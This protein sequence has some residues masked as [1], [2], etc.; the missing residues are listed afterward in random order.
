VVRGGAAGGESLRRSWDL[1]RA[2]G[3]EQ[4]EP[5][6][7][8]ATL[9]ADTVR[10]VQR[11]CTL[12][13][14]VVLDVGAGPRQFAEAFVG[15]GARYVG[16]DADPDALQRLDDRRAHALI[17]SG[18]HLPVADGALDVVISSNVFEHVRG[19][20]RLADE[21]VRVTRRGGMVFL[22]YT[23]WLS[24]W[25][26]HET[27]PYHYL[28]GERAVR[29]YTRRYGHPPKNQVGH[30]LFRTSV[31]Q[32]LRW[33]QGRPDV[34]LVEARPRYYP[35]YTRG[36]VRIPGVRE[37]VTWNLWLALRRL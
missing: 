2:F 5:E 36:L 24:P 1:V 19:P 7:F 10:L 17:A 12:R 21:M 13:D 37:V 4:T 9:A 14:A 23:N 29:R 22:S 26:G 6:R 28:G 16:I 18:T 34:R 8:Y 35:S 30:N 3:V 32:G 33:A 20:E 31:R 15:A 25:G 27:S 11:H